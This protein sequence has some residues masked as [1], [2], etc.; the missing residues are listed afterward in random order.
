MNQHHQNGENGAALIT[1]LLVLVVLST[2]VVAYVQSMS[3]ERGAS[4]SELRRLHAELAAE[5]ALSVAA[6]RLA[7]LIVRY[8]YHAVGM[9]QLNGQLTPVLVAGTSTTK[10]PS[11]TEY[12]ISFDPDNPTFNATNSVNL[13]FSRDNADPS[14][15]IGKPYNALRPPCRAHWIALLENPSLPVQPDPDAP[16]YNPVVARYAYWIE[17]ECAKL[18]L[19]T[20]GNASGPGA[21]FQRSPESNRPS[22]LDLGALPIG[23]DGQPL[24]PSDPSGGTRNAQAVD[25]RN[26]R[27][28]PEDGRVINQQSAFAGTDVAEAIRFHATHFSRS[29]D[30]AMT[31]RRRA[32]LNAI[33]TN[34]TDPDEI[35]ADLDDIGWIITGRH[36]MDGP[37]FL[38]GTTHSGLFLDEPSGSGPMPTFGDRFF[39]GGATGYPADLK[40][41]I[42]L[43]KLAA[44]VRDYIDADS[45][46]T[47]V[48]ASG[49]IA[50][51]FAPQ[52]APSIHEP[53]N[54]AIG[55]EAGPYLQEHAW[56]GYIE[57]GSWHQSGNVVTADLRFDHYFEFANP[58][59]RDYTAPWGAFLKVMNQPHWLAGSYPDLI[60]G[61]FRVDLSW[62]AIPAGD[63]VVVTTNTTRPHPPGLIRNERKLVPRAATG[64]DP[65]VDP[66]VFPGAISDEEIGEVRGFQL[67]GRSSSI[68]DY[69]TEC[70]IGTPNGLVSS[71]PALSISVSKSSQWN[72]TNRGQNVGSRTRFVYS[73]SLRGNDELSRSGDPRSLTEQLNWMDYRSDGNWD[74]TRFFGT[75]RGHGDKAHAGIPGSSTFG[76]SRIQYVEPADWPDYHI[77]LRD[78]AESAPAVIRDGTMRSIGELGHIYDPSR[79]RDSDIRHARGGG[80]SLKVGQR[81]D[82]VPAGRFDA[83]G[84]TTPWFNAAWRLCDLF[85]AANRTL[86]MASS[87]S[88]GKLNINGT[89]RDDGV[90]FRAALRAF[91]F[92][93][94]SREGNTLQ[95]SEITA[96]ISGLTEY[97]EQNG[98]MMERGEISQ[99]SFFSDSSW[100]GGQRNDLSI[101]RAREEIFRR[102]V[103]LITTRS[104]AFSIYALGEAVRQSPDG[105]IVPLSRS[106]TRRVVHLEPQAMDGSGQPV[107]L[108]ASTNAAITSRL[109]ISPVYESSPY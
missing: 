32:N 33:V 46:P 98:P 78:N 64:N 87:T 58:T 75:I 49:S 67:R 2:I 108:E 90:A 88:R 60:P 80:R 19:G 57:P 21:T 79:K 25:L 56:F 42:Y 23:E 30:T 95:E 71:F 77:V 92:E 96:L 99:L 31:G 10:T 85:A 52:F 55:K 17:D 4:R 109:A 8:P 97:L 86:P 83:S 103:E 59:T 76:L 101:D 12:L 104:A 1:V 22:D 50:P 105:R 45:Q 74:Q 9:Q 73:T 91:V 94:D 106:A 20:A 66:L 28:F 100:A 34:S 6:Q 35:A 29:L 24:A 65:N 37:H 15:W 107:P 38:S 26:R 18:D 13:N 39:V 62:I 63:V 47:V 61:D 27:S 102:I 11:I 81:D 51:P 48:S 43:R 54:Q 3:M 53:N 14:G 70:F 41:T 7:D 82:I 72:I 16:Q 84:G 36:I 69:V 93:E 44:N 5:S 40:H 89:L 68:T